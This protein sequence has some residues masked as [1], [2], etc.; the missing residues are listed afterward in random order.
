MFVCLFLQLFPQIEEIMVQPLRDSRDH[1]EELKQID[2]AMTEVNTPQILITLFVVLAFVL[3]VVYF[4]M[5]TLAEREIVRSA[6]M[7]YWRSMSKRLNLVCTNDKLVN[8]MF[9]KFWS[10]ACAVLN[11]FIR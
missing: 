10:H 8:E 4:L 3:L 1:Y 5:T 11:I 6:E 7:A 9:T 2:D